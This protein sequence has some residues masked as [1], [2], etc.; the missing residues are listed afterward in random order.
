MRTNHL[1]SMFFATL[2]CCIFSVSLPAQNF[3]KK[4]DKFTQKVEK[5]T[6]D[7]SKVN[8]SVQTVRKEVAE[9]TAEEPQ[10]ETAPEPE[11]E[12]SAADEP[13]AGT[14]TKPETVTTQKSNQS[15]NFPQPKVSKAKTNPPV[16]KV[17]GGQSQ[18]I[19]INGGNAT[20]QNML[21]SYTIQVLDCQ[22]N[23]SD[24]TVTI[25]FMVEH[26]LPNQTFHIIQKDTKA[27][28]KGQDYTNIDRYVGSKS[29]HNMVPTE[30]PM[31]CRVVIR[32]VVPSVKTFDSV[33]LNMKT[34]NKDGGKGGQK[35]SLEMKNLNINWN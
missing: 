33:M 10:Q 4:L 21:G 7:I 19:S 5:T 15:A 28:A 23:S 32:N 20:V 13:L 14:D 6:R 26:Q 12:T 16:V 30:I 27:Y 31:E 11:Q 9:F 2:F 34:Q 8:N 35:G 25:T 24:Q 1:T 17:P 22:G 3:F 29:F 18:K